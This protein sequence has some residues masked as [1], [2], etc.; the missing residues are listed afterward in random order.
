MIG[1]LA[2][3]DGLEEFRQHLGG[4]LTAC[5]WGISDPLG[6][7]KTARLALERG[8]SE[9]AV[10]LVCYRNALTAYGQSGQMFSNYPNRRR[11]FST[12]QNAFLRPSSPRCGMRTVPLESAT[13]RPITCA[14]RPWCFRTDKVG[15]TAS[16][17][18]M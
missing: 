4:E 3:L 12:G 18:T 6:V 7:P 8:I 16:G 9:Q 17:A 15:L 5:D 2:I 11:D 10:R 13:A 1:N 14:S